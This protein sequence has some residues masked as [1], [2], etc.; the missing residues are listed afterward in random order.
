MKAISWVMMVGL[1]LGTVAP[2]LSFATTASAT[3]VDMASAQSEKATTNNAAGA[4]IV[5]LNTADVSTLE[6][7]KGLGATKAQAIV[8]YRQQHGNFA[9]VE[10]VSKVPGIGPKML[11]KIQAELTV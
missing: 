3:S 2:E 4:G 10:D 9:S 7:I 11:A 5:N 8:N 6:T 1:M